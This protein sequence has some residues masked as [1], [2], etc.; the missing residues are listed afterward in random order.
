M[1]RKTKITLEFQIKYLHSTIDNIVNSA[2]ISIKFKQDI[3]KM[4]EEIQENKS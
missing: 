4:D 3:Y 2:M 1:K